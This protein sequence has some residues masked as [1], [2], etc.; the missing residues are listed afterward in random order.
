MHRIQSP[1]IIYQHDLVLTHIL[2]LI[3]LNQTEDGSRNTVISTTVRGAFEI[4][5]V[6]H[7][8]EAEEEVLGVERLFKVEEED[9]L[10]KI[11]KVP[12]LIRISII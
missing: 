2:A 10:S 7:V 4:K 8:I 12:T 3:G 6:L 11:G 5:V 1:H 9:R